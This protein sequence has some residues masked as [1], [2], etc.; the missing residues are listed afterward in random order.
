MQQTQKVKKTIVTKETIS[1]SL[2]E[3]TR[4]WIHKPYPLGA[5]L[6]NARKFFRFRLE[7]FR[8]EHK[9][10]DEFLIEIGKLIKAENNHDFNNIAKFIDG[11]AETN[12]VS[13]RNT[14]FDAF[15][16]LYNLCLSPKQAFDYINKCLAKYKEMLGFDYELCGNLELSIRRSRWDGRENKFISFVVKPNIELISYLNC[17]YWFEITTSLTIVEDRYNDVTTHVHEFELRC[18]HEIV[19]DA[20]MLFEYHQNNV[21]LRK[22]FESGIKELTD[23][24]I[25]REVGQTD[26][27]GWIIHEYETNLKISNNNS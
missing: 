23:K 24:K 22:V 19:E 1:M 6:A 14:M 4:E 7:R 17:Q 18:K 2:E 27:D 8:E 3:R 21:L 5:P 13:P 20:L 15:I 16:K 12:W 10:F 25:I 26:S 11:E 9:Q